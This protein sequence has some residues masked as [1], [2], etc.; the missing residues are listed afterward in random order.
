MIRVGSLPGLSSTNFLT[1]G[2]RIEIVNKYFGTAL[3]TVQY[4]TAQHP[5]VLR[6][7]CT[8]RSITV[9]DMDVADFCFYK[10]SYREFLINIF[11][12]IT[13]LRCYWM[14][15]LPWTASIFLRLSCLSAV[16]TGRSRSLHPLITVSFR[17]EKVRT[18]A[19][20]NAKSRRKQSGILSLDLFH[21]PNMAH[22]IARLAFQRI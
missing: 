18:L 21:F 9:V 19:C 12:H 22:S 7:C 1:H 14:Y 4:S 10:I 2:R 6:Y 11:P 15:L 17:S 8:R 13:L 16:L 20:S 5:L 3:F